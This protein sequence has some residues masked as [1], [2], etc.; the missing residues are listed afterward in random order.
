MAT[1]PTDRILDW[2]SG[3]TTTDPGGT[4]EAAGWL[5]S[6]RPPAFWW[7]WILNSFGQWLTW[8][9]DEIDDIPATV[10]TR[11]LGA[12]GS[13]GSSNSTPLINTSAQDVGIDTPQSGDVTSTLITIRFSTPFADTLYTPTLTEFSGSGDPLIFTAATK[14]VSSLTVQVTIADTGAVHNPLTTAAT[15]YVDIKGAI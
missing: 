1:K 7:N 14:N 10:R 9:E 5:V 13:Q 11:V 2:G 3:G 15:F 12:F 4:K 8:A 6:E